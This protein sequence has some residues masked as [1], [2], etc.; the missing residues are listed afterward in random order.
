M[1]D[2][3]LSDSYY[4]D[5]SLVTTAMTTDIE[6]HEAARVYCENLVRQSSAVTFSEL[7]RLEFAH[8][9]R[10]V[11]RSLHPQTIRLYGLHRWEREP[12]RRHW[13]D[14]S[15]NRFETFLSLFADVQEVRL[16]REIIEYANELMITCNLDSYDA[17]HVATALATGAT[18]IVTLDRHYERV[19]HIIDVHII[20]DDI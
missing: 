9:L 11:V 20:P 4:L 1:D 14:T 13:I 5:T 12:I 8:H 17:A 3:G 2:A 19:R 10:V 15:F 6:Q 16:T 18:R 7:L